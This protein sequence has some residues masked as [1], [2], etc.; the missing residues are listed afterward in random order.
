MLAQNDLLEA[1]P[2]AAYTT[3][4]EGRLTFFNRAAAE[5]IDLDPAEAARPVSFP[6][7][8]SLLTP[9]PVPPPLAQFAGGRSSV[10]GPL[11]TRF[12]PASTAG[13]SPSAWAF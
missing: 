7:F 12:S 9:K 4:V 11:W 10:T 1:L 13:F 8:R 6:K 3:D 5:L 2:V